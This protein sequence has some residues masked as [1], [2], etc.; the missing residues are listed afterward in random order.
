MFA[1]VVFPKS[2]GD[3]ASWMYIPALSHWHEVISYSWGSAVL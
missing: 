1:T 2:T 3:A